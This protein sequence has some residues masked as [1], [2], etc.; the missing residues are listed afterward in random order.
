MDEI[1]KSLATLGF[2]SAEI[3]VYGYLFE[4]GVVSG[5]EIMYGLKRDKSSTYRSLNLLKEKGLIDSIGQSRNQKFKI[6]DPKKIYQ[7]LNNKKKELD[8]TSKTLNSFLENYSDYK[9]SKYL[10]QNIKI[11][12][13]PNAYYQ[14]RAEILKEKNTVVRDLTPSS[15]H[16]YNMAGSRE[17]YTNDT[18]TFIKKRVSRNIEMR[19]LYDSNV[20][21]EEM[22]ITDKT[23][24][25]VLKTA[26][27]FPFKLKFGC[28]MNTFA[29][30]TAFMNSGGKDV[31][32]MIIQDRLVTELFN[33]LF[34]VLWS[35]SKIVNK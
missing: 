7:I 23:D 11:F 35:Q 22:D 1:S 27:Q 6:D 26:K 24:L 18:K 4:N 14:L 34:D 30:K 12:E 32:I 31:W 15:K 25:Q 33:S 29:D 17:N 3:D 16:A 21:P 10:A 8:E 19:V 13:G 9:N 5:P 20:T 2:S 28:S